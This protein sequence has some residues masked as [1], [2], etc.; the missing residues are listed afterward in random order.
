MPD[1]HQT[2]RPDNQHRYAIYNRFA[3][4]ITAFKNIDNAPVTQPYKN[5]PT[6]LGPENR[7][8]PVAFSRLA[9]ATDNGFTFQRLRNENRKSAQDEQCRQRHNKTRQSGLYHDVAIQRPE[10]DTDHKGDQNC[11]PHRP[12]QRHPENGD[13]HPRKT[14][15][16]PD[17][18]IK[19]AR[20][21]QKT[22]THCDNHELR[23]DHGP[24]HH[25][26]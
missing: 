16:R 11:Y 20:D 3:R 17:G 7:C 13:H 21:H 9:D 5:W 22:R 2:K 24:V 19:L 18:Q 10:R 12:T 8:Q 25:A 1:N 26:L 6:D 23:R 15:H 4:A 14:D